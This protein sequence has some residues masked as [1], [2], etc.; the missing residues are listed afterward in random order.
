MNVYIR[1]N[2][3]G[4]AWPLEL[5]AD[6]PR[7]SALRGQLLEYSNTSLSI[8][9]I[10]GV[11]SSGE[12]QWDVLFDIGQG[13]VPF[14]VQNGNRLPD[15][16]I[17][18]HLHYDHISGLDWLVQSYKRNRRKETPLPVYT[19]KPCWDEVV[20]RFYWLKDDMKLRELK[21]GENC[22]VEEAPGLSL[23]AF[24]VFHGDYAPGASLLL[25]QYRTD[26]RSL[27]YQAIFT[28]DLLC[29]LLREQD[30]ERLR[31]AHVIYADANTRF[32]WPRSGHWSIVDHDARKGIGTQSTAIVSW[33]QRFHPSYLL[34]P[35]S[36][37]FEEVTHFFLDEFLNQ[38]GAGHKLYWSIFEF[39]R[40]IQPQ[41]V[42]LVH[43][44]GYEDLKH[45]EQAILDYERLLD[46][47]QNE[48]RRLDLSVQWRIPKPGDCLPLFSEGV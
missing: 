47:T 2:G 6:N 41:D 10:N 36:R 45:H 17:L 9:G 21:P 5:G 22:I 33:K 19:S 27:P 29:P 7:D 13:I 25:A 43:Y 46:W 12:L 38:V 20:L 39:V 16:V 4:N 31:G 44:S 42:Q 34:T 24:P 23:I 8:L 28:G 1:V 26:T 32:P 18:S 35:H 40:R 14:L 30:F 48:A 37:G 3:R 11:P 15:A